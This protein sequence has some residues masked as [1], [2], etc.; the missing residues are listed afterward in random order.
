MSA[1]ARYKRAGRT[2]PIPLGWGNASVATRR[3]P[4]RA[5]APGAIGVSASAASRGTLYAVE[6]R[7]GAGA[8]YG[9]RSRLLKSLAA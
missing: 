3:L 8:G 7:S 6:E 1:C 4:G 2:A 9:A 5:A